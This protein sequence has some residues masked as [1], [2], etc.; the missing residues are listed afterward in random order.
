MMSKLKKISIKNITLLMFIILMTA[1]LGTTGFIVFSKW[2]ESAEDIAGQ[3]AE[4]LSRDITRDIEDYIGNPESINLAH[5]AM[6]RKD[7]VDI[8]DPE[9]RERFFLGV[10]GSYSGESIYSFSYGTE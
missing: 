6:I 1:T 10:L 3:L 8:Y 5:E 2:M 7:I 9:D 4:D